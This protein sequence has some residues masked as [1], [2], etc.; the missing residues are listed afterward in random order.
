MKKF[1][2]ISTVFIKLEIQLCQRGIRHTII[3]KA[4]LYAQLSYISEH[5]K[6]DTVGVSSQP[7]CTP[8]PVELAC[9]L[10]GSDTWVWGEAPPPP[11]VPAKVLMRAE[12][13]GRFVI[14]N[15]RKSLKTN[16]DKCF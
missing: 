8:E 10:V 3:Y 13:T 1:K 6:G 11:S 2:Y 9:T 7:G 14:L 4:Q 16:T 15:S 5:Y 12:M